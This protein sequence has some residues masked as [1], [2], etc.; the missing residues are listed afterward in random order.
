MRQFPTPILLLLFSLWV[1]GPIDDASMQSAWADEAAVDPVTRYIPDDAMAAI[2]VT[3]SEWLNSPMLEMFP[4]EIMRVQMTEQFGIDPF[5]IGEIRT[6]VSLDP[7]TMQPAFGSITKLTGEIDFGKV[8]AAIDAREDMV[9]VD[10]HETYPMNGPPGTVIAMIDDETLYAG[11]ANLLP[12]M[13]DAENG[14]GKLPS[15]LRTM[16][17]DSGVKIA[18]LTE[19]VR[20]M[21]GPVAMQNAHHL[22]PDL[23]ALA[24]IPGLIDAIKVEVGLLDSTGRLRVALIGTD[25]VAA[26]RIQSILIDSMSAAR[27][28]G[29]AEM[30]RSLAGSGESPAMR[31]ATN[32]YANRIADMVMESLQPQLDGDEVAIETQ[33]QASFATTGVLVG[34]LL[35]AVQAAR[36]AARRMSMS[37]NMKQVGLALHNYHSAFRQLPPSAITDEDG[38]PLLSWRVAILSFIEEQALY[39][40][41]RLDEPWDSEHNLPLSKQLPAVYSAPNT[42]TPPGTTVMQAVVGDDIGLRPLEKTSFRDFLD[43]LSNSILVMQVD[44]DAAVIWSKPEDLEIDM[45]N[46]ME[47]LGNAERGGFHVLMGDGAVRFMTDSVDVD[48]LKKLLTRAGKEVVNFP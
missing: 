48:L 1:T 3:P 22:A 12:R 5:D 27:S 37:N 28:L 39:Q 21:I 14:S 40:Q 18:I 25:E 38:K 36:T 32:A 11:T 6:I 17:S 33:S 44:P 8:R 26:Q 7:T 2:I 10:G 9:Q 31:E 23:Q 16:N 13:L 41:F 47:H 20:P 34:L 24:E 19:Q 42:Q 15:L 35:P 29:I 30:N 43:G 4:L 45:D 46:P